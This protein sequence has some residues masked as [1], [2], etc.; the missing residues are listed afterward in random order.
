MSSNLHRDAEA[1]AKLILIWGTANRLERLAAAMSICD[2]D[3]YYLMC[4]DDACNVVND[5]HCFPGYGG[6]STVVLDNLLPENMG[7]IC[8][9]IEDVFWDRLII[10]SPSPY[11]LVKFR[12]MYNMER[13]ADEYMPPVN[14]YDIRASSERIRLSVQH[15]IR[16]NNTS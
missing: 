15:R 4:S 14:C 1:R 7:D 9:L 10:T 16:D 3:T 12:S 13:L 5:C 6:E 8:E 11:I 2:G